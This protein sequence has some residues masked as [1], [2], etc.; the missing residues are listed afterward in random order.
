MMA[1]VY[2]IL[3]AFYFI[4]ALSL[5]LYGLN[6]LVMVYLYQRRRQAAAQR[7]N[8]IRSISSK[9]TDPETVPVVTTQIAIY[10]E[11]N[12][13]E[14]V[15]RA[16]CEMQYPKGRHEIQI[17]DDSTDDTRTIV[18]RVAEELHK[19][20]HDINVIRRTNRSGFKAGALGNGLSQ[21]RGSLIAVFDADFLPTPEFLLRAVPFFLADRKVGLV[22]AR[23]GH[24]NAKRSLITRAQA[25][26]IDGHFMVEQ[27]ARNWNRLYMNFNG[28]AGIWRKAAIEAGGGWQWDTLTEDMDL[29]Y[30]VQIAGWQTQYVQDLV[31]PAEIPENINAFKSQQ[32]RWAKGSTQTALKILPKLIHCPVSNFK[33]LQAFFHMTHYFVHP[34]MLIMA[35]MALPVLL[36][37]NV[38]LPTMAYM[39]F[40][41]ILTLCMV[42]P[43]TLYLISQRHAYS[44][45]IQ[46]VVFLPALVIIGVGVAVSN[47]RA[48]F[49]AL[50]GHKSDFVRT[51]KSGDRTL[52]RYRAT[53]P[54]LAFVEIIIG[55]YCFYSFSIYLSLG[56]YWVGPF[57]AIYA[58]GFMFVGC[59]T[60]I[61]H[62]SNR[63]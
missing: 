43:N 63:Y 8:S 51:P 56:K 28:T 46:R 9:Q 45:W 34:L 59:L 2:P 30:R 49:E 3:V 52:K 40:V 54:Y 7:V 44:D 19:K 37:L 25:I 48:V 12:V 57:L 29:S 42:A 50:L 31:V 6:C 47:T 10:N 23:W 1:I 20:G 5:M 39:L 61:H 35:L 14:R 11:I 18:D 41:L 53:F 38:A 15:M 21:A 27:A 4:V 55:S 58:S 13:A 17:L 16:A 22:Q 32:F 26:G 36:F 24:L 60:L 62:F 33:K